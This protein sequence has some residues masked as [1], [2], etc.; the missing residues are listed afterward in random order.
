M[1]VLK[2]LT[3]GARSKIGPR[4]HDIVLFCMPPH[5]STHLWFCF[6]NT[7]RIPIRL[8]GL[9]TSARLPPYLG[10]VRLTSYDLI[11]APKK[12]QDFPL[13]RPMCSL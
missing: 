7:S 5:M 13:P 8:Q 6:Q 4:L 1:K 11:L 3:G 12:A 9:H 10:N 2:G